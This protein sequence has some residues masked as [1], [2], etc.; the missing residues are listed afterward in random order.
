MRVLNPAEIESKPG[1]PDY[2]TGAVAL[3]RMAETAPPTNVKL[4][5]VE[6]PAGAR[7]HWHTHTG[8][9]ILVVAEGRCRFQ[10]EEGPVQEAGTGEVIHIPAGEK[11]WHGATPDAPMVHLAVNIDAETD[12][13]EAVS[14]EEYGG[15]R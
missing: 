7:T 12:W 13:L 10:H 1:S 14:E 9:Q 3:R 2:F 8:V 6:F 5:R 11:H 15:A 4:F